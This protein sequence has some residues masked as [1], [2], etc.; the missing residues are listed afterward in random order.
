MSELEAAQE[1]GVTVMVH[2][3]FVINLASLNN[4]IRIPGRKLLQQHLTAAAEAAIAE[5]FDA[6]FRD[7]TVPLTEAEAAAE[8]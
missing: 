2:S 3:P 1:A 7:S 5:A 8:P 4:R 6:T